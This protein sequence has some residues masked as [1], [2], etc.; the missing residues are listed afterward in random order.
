MATGLTVPQ[1]YFRAAS[2]GHLEQATGALAQLVA[3]R[4][5]EV[6]T[7]VVQV[8]RPVLCRRR[9]PDRCPIPA[10]RRIAH[11]EAWDPQHADDAHASPE[12]VLRGHTLDQ[13]LQLTVDPRPADAATALP[14]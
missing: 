4:F 12:T 10:H 2:R 1:R 5:P 8:R 9:S 3:E 11:L 13:R 6:G 14:T 7:V